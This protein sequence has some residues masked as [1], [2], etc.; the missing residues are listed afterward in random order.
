MWQCF[1]CL[2]RRLKLYCFS[3]KMSSMWIMDTQM[4]FIQM[5]LI[6]M[7]VIQILLV[8]FFLCMP[9]FILSFILLQFW[10][11]LIFWISVDSLFCFV[12]VKTL[13]MLQTIDFI[14]LNNF[15]N[16][17]I[18]N[19]VATNILFDLRQEMSRLLEQGH[20]ISCSVSQTFLLRNKN[21]GTKKLK[22]ISCF[23]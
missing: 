15:L 18:L 23:S 6:Q 4:S 14:W 11:C 17:N 7:Y 22:K 3:A 1:C 2:F 13:A 10:F 20:K 8:H 19:V 5:P 12:L 9:L 21:F 16:P